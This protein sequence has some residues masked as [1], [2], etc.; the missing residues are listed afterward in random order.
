MI[1]G[2]ASGLAV[3]LGLFALSVLLFL[4][5]EASSWIII[6][7][8]FVAAS[9][10]SVFFWHNERSL[11][12]PKG[13]L[14]LALFSVPIGAIFLGI[15][16]LLGRFWYPDM[17]LLQVTTKVGGLFGIVVTLAVCPGLTFIALAG[18]ARTLFLVHNL[19]HG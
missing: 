3:L 1:I 12:T 10:I 8:L 11:D 14:Q 9:A 7:F 13:W 6:S 5:I 17:P 4:P 19:G 15:D 16:I 2:D 18:S